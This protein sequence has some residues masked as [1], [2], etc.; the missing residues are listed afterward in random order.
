MRNRM[1]EFHGLVDS[2]GNLI[3]DKKITV[4]GGTT[5]RRS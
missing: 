1:L 5:P 4:D 2:R 3:T